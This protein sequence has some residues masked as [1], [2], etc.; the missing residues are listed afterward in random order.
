VTHPERHN[1]HLQ[2]ALQQRANERS[3]HK[4]TARQR[5]RAACA[6]LHQGGTDKNSAAKEFSAFVQHKAAAHQCRQESCTSIR[7]FLTGVL[8]Q[9]AQRFCPAAA[10]QRRR[11]ACAS[12]QRSRDE[13]KG[14]SRHHRS[15]QGFQPGHKAAARQ[16]L[17]APGLW[18]KAPRRRHSNAAAAAAVHR[19]SRNA[20]QRLWKDTR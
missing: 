2:P 19:I 14:N 13:I 12:L 17:C 16:H 20:E 1:V 11:A 5:R 7:W 18:P 9:G 6:P 8:P 10:R 15:L 3:R 4:A